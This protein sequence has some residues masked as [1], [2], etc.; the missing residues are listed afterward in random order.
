MA[1]DRSQRADV[2]AR[3]AAAQAILDAEA[4]RDAALALKTQL[5]NEDFAILVPNPNAVSSEKLQAAGAQVKAE[6]ASKHPDWQGIMD[7]AQAAF[8]A[9]SEQ[10]AALD[11]AHSGTPVQSSMASR[12]EAYHAALQAKE[13]KKADARKKFGSRQKVS[14]DLRAASDAMRAAIAKVIADN[15]RADPPVK[16]STQEAEVVVRKT[17]PDVASQYVRA[18]NAYDAVT[19]GAE[20]SGRFARFERVGGPTYL[21]G[22]STGIE[23]AISKIFHDKDADAFVARA[24]FRDP[25]TGQSK[26]IT[27]R[28]PLADLRAR[29][30]ACVM[31][32]AQEESPTE[33]VS[34]IWDTIKGAAEAVVKKTGVAAVVNKVADLSDNPLFAQGLQLA[35]QYFPPLGVSYGAVL[36]GAKLVKAV[37]NGDTG[38]IQQVLDV[39]QQAEAGNPDATTAAQTLLTISR[40][41]QEGVSPDEQKSLAEKI[42]STFTSTAKN[43]GSGVASFVANPGAAFTKASDVVPGLANNPN[44]TARDIALAK[45][46][47][48]FYDAVRRAESIAGTRRSPPG[49]LGKYFKRRFAAAGWVWDP[50]VGCGG[51]VSASGGKSAS[52]VA[53]AIARRS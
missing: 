48:D 47:Q 52:Q 34:G 30:R 33:A 28:Y 45:A 44:A 5:M 8:D 27:V 19:R 11:A 3:Q 37:K 10:M 18:M 49:R 9:A 39:K 14:D 26:A 6:F 4:Q 24:D 40:A 41:A 16:L 22:Q 50:K 46:V 7:Q 17:M 36:A 12:G 1:D 32:R 35:G 15:L 31:R 21:V 53:L 29:V 51:S 23:V 38:A 43:I 13:K 42:A 25:E 20:V 2:Q